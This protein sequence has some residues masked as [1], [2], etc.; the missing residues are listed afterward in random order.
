MYKKVL[1]A[2]NEHLNS[3]AAARYAIHFCKA[4]GSRLWFCH[5]RESGFSEEA[6]ALAAEAVKRLL[7]S[8]HEAAVEA[9][10]MVAEGEPAGAIGTA[11]RAEGIDLVF[12]STRREDVK[13]RFFKGT[14]SRRLAVLPCSVALVRAV[15]MGRSHPKDIIVPVKERVRYAAE[16][17]YFS[18][19][20]A[21]AFDAR[22]YLFHT[23]RPIT[24]FFSGEIDIRPVEWEQRVSA[25]IL[26]FMKLLDGHGV[27]H[28]RRLLPGRAGRS[29]TV[30]AA[31]K[32]S[33]LIIMG[34]SERGLL[35][36]FLLGSPVEEVLRKTPC[37]LIIFKPTRENF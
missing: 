32:R 18:A 11:V 1:A 8:A 27:G 21:R 12:A 25:D 14:V 35:H 34:A 10:S 29:I 6:D 31:A 23:A 5:V 26:K 37:D 24:K 30:E 13:R 7:R 2:V 16:K 19:M 33:D 15:R 22:I 36:S 20:M 4:A 3:E 17:A 9:E 28:E